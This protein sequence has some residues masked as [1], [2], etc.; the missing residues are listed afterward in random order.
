MRAVGAN[1]AAILQI[2]IGE[3]MLIGFLS[4]LVGCLLALPLGSL[5]GSMVG[6]GFLQ[7]PLSSA[8]SFQGAA[9]WLVIVLAISA[10][11]SLAPAVLAV[12]YSVREVLG[13]E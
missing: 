1:Q 13:Y 2:V 5:L 10:V 7:A 6:M 11:A 4:W 12:R 9:A 8:Y 3:G